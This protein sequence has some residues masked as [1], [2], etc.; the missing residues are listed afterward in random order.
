MIGSG[1]NR[2]QLMD[3]EDMCQ[4]ILASITVDKAKANDTFNIGAEKYTTMKEDYQVVL[5]RAGYGKKIKT[6]PAWLVIPVLKVL[7]ALKLSP[8]IPGSTRRLPRIPLY[9][10]KKPK[11]CW[12]TSPSTPTRMP[13]C[14]IMN[15]I[16][17]TKTSSAVKKGFP[18]VYPGSRKHSS[19]SR[20]S[21]R[22]ETLH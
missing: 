22:E 1:K 8:S 20:S 6:F 15:G 12:I 9:P 2:Y 18:T 10:S 21:S 5:D 14:G 16:W 11:R 4:A 17:R 19:W 13:C 3:V 7:E